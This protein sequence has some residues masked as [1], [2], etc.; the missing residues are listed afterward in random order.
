MA[1]RRKNKLCHVEANDIK[2]ITAN[3]IWF[4]AGT[5]LTWSSPAIPLLQRDDSPF[6][7]TDDEA[8]WVGSLLPL[9]AVFGGPPFGMLVNRF[10]R[11]PTLLALA[12]P[13]MVGWV[14]IL[15]THS[16]T[17]L[18]VARFLCGLCLGGISFSV[19]IYVAEISEPSVRGLLCSIAQVTCNLGILCSYAVGA[20][21]SYLALNI[22]CLA[23]PVIFLL[24]FVW[25][26]E[27]PHY[28]I[29]QN[30]VEGARKSLQWLR[31]KNCNIDHELQILTVV[32]QE[33]ATNKVSSKDA[34]TDA[35]AIKALLISVGLIIAQQMGGVSVIFFNTQGIFN[36]TGSELSDTLS[37]V[38]VGL[39][40]AVMA[41]VTTP[42][43][44]RVGRRQLL[45][46]SSIVSMVS[47]FVLGLYFLLKEQLQ[48][49]VSSIS[50]LPLASLMVFICV[51]CLG[52]GS[53]PWIVMSE[54]LPPSIK[55]PAGAVVATVCWM[56]SFLL[57]NTFQMF[58]SQAGLFAVFW[59]FA[60]AC[61]LSSTFIFFA[62]PETKGISLQ[63][64]QTKMSKNQTK[65][66]SDRTDMTS[67]ES[68]E[69]PNNPNNENIKIP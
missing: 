36:A 4:A 40:M 29:S 65:C 67:L 5:M 35:V 45:L 25:M 16:V 47:V 34:F 53:L 30:D 9:G 14:L 69:L 60:A 15:V 6:R 31:G 54:V 22:T 49:D 44:D 52:L 7:I 58:V 64:I 20:S 50:W 21:G 26:P 62:V 56:T 13:M 18:Y 37:S 23:I 57:T 48:R 59:F 63:E 3:M 19:H 8:S 55:G 12:L 39:A 41:F 10:G 43:V 2:R 66:E 51:Y 33:N 61:A 38:I 1:R 28:L 24:M 42:I 27:S 11:K 17:Y 46:L 68:I 32:S